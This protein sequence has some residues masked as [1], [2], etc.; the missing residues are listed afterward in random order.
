MSNLKIY[1]YCGNCKDGTRTQVGIVYDPTPS[2]A[3]IQNPMSYNIAP[4]DLGG[5]TI[6]QWLAAR[7]CKRCD[8]QDLK[9]LN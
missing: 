1:F 5:L 3:Y 2:I 4:A 7:E 9:E 8:K 6:S